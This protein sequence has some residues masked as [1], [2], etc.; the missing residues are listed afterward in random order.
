M[1]TDQNEADT[2][3][4][5]GGYGDAVDMAAKAPTLTGVLV[6]LVAGSFVWAWQRLRRRSRALLR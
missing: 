6:A 3:A 5:L 1:S 4:V 2:N